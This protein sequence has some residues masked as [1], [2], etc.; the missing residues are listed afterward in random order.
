MIVPTGFGRVYRG[1]CYVQLLSHLRMCRG[2]VQHG[3]VKGLKKLKNVWVFVQHW[4]VKGLK[5]IK[6]V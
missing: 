4:E 2:S 6:N 1:K 3:K 5:K